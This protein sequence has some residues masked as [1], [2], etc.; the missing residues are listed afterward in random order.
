MQWFIRSQHLRLLVLLTGPMPDV[1]LS[2]GHSIQVFADVRGQALM[3]VAN[4]YHPHG[5]QSSLNSTHP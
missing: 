3:A 4:W 1:F 2:S 5:L